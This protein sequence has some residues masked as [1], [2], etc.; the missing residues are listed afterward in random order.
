MELT[1]RVE[2]LSFGY[3]GRPVLHDVT[4][5][6]VRTSQVTAVVGPNAAGKSTLLRCIAGLHRAR[7][8]VRIDGSVAGRSGIFYLPQE[9]LPASSLTVFEAVLLARRLG[10]G[11]GAGGP[12]DVTEVADTLVR[13]RLDDLATTPLGNMSGGQRQLVALAQAVVRRPEVLLLDE[14]VSNL[15]L[16]NQLR[17]LTLVRE[18]AA[19]QSTAVLVTVHDL[20]LAARFADEA[21]VLCDGAVHAS[22]TPDEVITAQML[23]EVYRVE[24]DVRRGEDGTLT[25]AAHRSL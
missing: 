20:T 8:T 14:P 9:P 2:G 17:V 6:E 23:R 7:G 16:R 19:E 13:L 21:I 24:G 3:R 5:P 1:L 18:L 4:L 10:P 15:D 12:D 25:V 11:A 22:G